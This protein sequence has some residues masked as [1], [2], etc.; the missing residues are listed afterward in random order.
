MTYQLVMIYTSGSES[1]HEYPYPS[2]LQASAEGA[3]L[4][5]TLPLIYKDYRVEPVGEIKR[6]F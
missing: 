1:R 4:V 3:Y 2:E 5:E 6:L